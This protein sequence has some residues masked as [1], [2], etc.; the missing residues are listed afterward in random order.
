MKIRKIMSHMFLG[1]LFL[2]VGMVFDAQANSIWTFEGS[3]I[4]TSTQ[5]VHTVMA[6][7]ELDFGPTVSTVTP[8]SVGN[9]SSSALMV[10][11]PNFQIGVGPTS[12]NSFTFDETTLAIAN[13]EV[14]PPNNLGCTDC[15]WTYF[16]IGGGFIQTLSATILNG[17]EWELVAQVIQVPVL[18][19]GG[20]PFGENIFGEFIL[21]GT[22]QW[23]PQ[24]II[25][26][27]VPEP[28]TVFLVGTGLVVLVGW[29]IRNKK[30]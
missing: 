25:S 17:N 8:F 5:E 24:S 30:A 11:G 23:T 10:S 22:G 12:P 21:R 1:M 19:L 27:P 4:D 18:Q 13:G 28:D 16:S 14:L 7:L 6:F 9:I 26:N 15:L 2:P 20:D 29:Q 3:G